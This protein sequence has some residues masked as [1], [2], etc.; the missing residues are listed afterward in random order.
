ML[1]IPKKLDEN[2]VVELAKDHLST[3]YPDVVAE[4]E[5]NAERIAG[6]KREKQLSELRSFVRM[7][8]GSVDDLARRFGLDEDHWLVRFFVKYPDGTAG[9]IPPTMVRVYESDYRVELADSK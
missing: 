7:Q 2:S 1:K 8:G 4:S 9:T 3:R 6:T 5:V